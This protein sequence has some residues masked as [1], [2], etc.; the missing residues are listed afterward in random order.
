[1]G[2]SL[3]LLKIEKNGTN[4]NNSKGIKLHEGFFVRKDVLGVGR[5]ILDLRRVKGN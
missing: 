2:V 5:W 3:P 1:M 4:I